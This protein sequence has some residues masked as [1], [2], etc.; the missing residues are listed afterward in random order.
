[1]DLFTRLYRDAGQ[2]NIK[3]RMEPVLVEKGLYRGCRE[4][5]EQKLKRRRRQLWKDG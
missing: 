5:W 3:T 4:S 1:M 2:Q